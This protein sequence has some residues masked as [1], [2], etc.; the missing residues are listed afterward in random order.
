MVLTKKEVKNLNPGRSLVIQCENVLRLDS[1]YQTALQARKEMGLTS[2]ELSINRSGKTMSVTVTR[3][4]G[5]VYNVS[6]DVK[7]LTVTVETANNA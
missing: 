6:Q 4:E 3:K 7:A 1:T 2:D 5:N